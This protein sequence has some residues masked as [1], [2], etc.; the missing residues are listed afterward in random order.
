MHE[1]ARDLHTA[2]SALEGRAKEG[3]RR[4]SERYSRR[5]AAS[6]AGISDRRINDWVP[7]DPAK[8]KVPHDAHEDVMALIRVWSQWAGETRVDQ[9]YWSNLI[10]A[11]QPSRKRT[12][13]VSGAGPG[14]PIAEAVDPFAFEVHQAIEVGKPGIGGVLPPLTSYISR[15]HDAQLA[16]KLEDAANGRSVMATLIGGSSCGKTRACWEAV[17]TLPEGWRLWHPLA[18]GHAEALLEDIDRVRPRTV[19]WLNEAQ[20][21]LDAR[22]SDLGERAAAKLRELLRDASRAPV[23]IVATLW[24]EYWRELT[25]NSEDAPADEH[26]HA[27]MLLVGTDIHVPDRFDSVDEQAALRLAR[28]DP[29]LEAALDGAE[30]GMVIQYLAGG[31]ALLD[32]FRTAP[33]GA[34]ALIRAAMDARWLGHGLEIPL[35]LLEHA[36][37]GYLTDFERDMLKDD[38]LDSALEECGRSVRGTRGPLTRVKSQTREADGPLYRLA[39]FLEQHGYRSRQNDVV[40]AALWEACTRYAHSSA[41][42]HL[43]HYARHYGLYQTAM[44]LTLRRQ[45]V[46]EEERSAAVAAILAKIDGVYAAAAR[47]ERDAGELPLSINE[48]ADSRPLPR[49]QTNKARRDEMLRAM[50]E[51]LETRAYAGDAAAY[52][53]LAFWLRRARP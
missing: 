35:P 37:L 51:T 36:A 39:D 33:P 4:K 52:S 6:A 9:R 25:H 46:S 49:H 50:V 10:D 2:L 44:E 29:R 31:P 30:S 16:R 43:A 12:G 38:W 32:R 20:N 19:I 42:E 24:P 48:D 21:Y 53:K 23:V 45:Y 8:A 1:A 15:E 13:T 17:H 28:A 26:P 27:R 34:R 7:G 22:R 3:R 5:L 47:L 18:P 11:A 40:P 14:I 41:C